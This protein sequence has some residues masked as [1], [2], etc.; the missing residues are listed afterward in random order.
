MFVTTKS[1]GHKQL[2]IFVL[3]DDEWF[4]NFLVHSISMNP[5]FDVTGFT[6]VGA[7]MKALPQ[8]PDLITLDFKL[9]DTTGDQVLA[10][11]KA[12]DES[13][14]VIIISEQENI[15]T[16]VELL[17]LGAFDYIVKSK[18]IRN[19]LL[20]IIQTLVKQ[21]DLYER[22]EEL[23]QEVERKYEF[24]HSIIGNSEA[25]KKIFRLI[26]KAV[27]TNITVSVTGETG[28]G[29]ELVAKAIHFNSPRKSKSFVAL[30]V[31]AIPHELIESELFGHEKGAF[32]GANTRRI[33]KFEEADGGTLFLDEIG[34]MP[35]TAQAKLLRA[36]QEKEIVRIG[37]NTVVK[38]E[39]R[40]V[41]ATH[42]NLAKE[43]QKGN[44]REDLYYRILGL[45]I[46]LPALKDRDKDVLVSA[47][48][49]IEK[50]AKDNQVSPK[51]LSDEAQQKLLA[52]KWPGNI[53]ELKSVIELALVL[54]DDE[55]VSADDIKLMTEDVLP[56]IM[57]KEITMREYS[58]S[59][60]DIYLKKYHNDIPLVAQKLDIS[61]ATIYRMLK[62]MKPE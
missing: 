61:Q 41:V 42:K 48:Y 38:V 12:F 13:I 11:I 55:L 58:L 53:R 54:G 43:V 9:G 29:K 52:H 56:Q 39:C 51:K 44:F 10:K 47:K 31:A 60:L 19:R 6:E 1:M 26:E 25:L 22:I 20:H 46:E 50:F 23:Q 15:E 18:D 14:P 4:N 5:D 35:L 28:T 2:K 8:G 7:F 37:S 49:F 27:E 40:I 3:E 24:Q 57:E 32:T 30:N 59:I 21:K 45:P 33:G 36:I 62:E 34:E 17:K 16:A